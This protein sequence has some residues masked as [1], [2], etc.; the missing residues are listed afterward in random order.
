MKRI[1]ALILTVPLL[2]AGC[3]DATT[4]ADSPPSDASTE[5]TPESTTA[6]AEPAVAEIGDPIP[7]TCFWEDCLGEVTFTNI[8]IDEECRYGLANYGESSNASTEDKELVQL[9]GEFSLTKG[10]G[11]QNGEEN[12]TSLQ[13]P[14]SVIDADGFIQT[15][16]AYQ[17]ED[18]TDG[19]EDW[20]KIIDASQK[21]RIY[22]NFLVPAGATALIVE[23]YTITLPGREI[24][25]NALMELPSREELESA[26]NSGSPVEDLELIEDMGTT[27]GIYYDAKNSDYRFCDSSGIN[28]LD[29]LGPDGCSEG[30][31]YE[32]LQVA[33]ADS[34][35]RSF[36]TETP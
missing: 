12:S 2:L 4:T 31:S 18:A 6:T 17:C 20:G 11:G 19:Y 21:V 35:A 27:L 25:E 14:T 32:E 9:W 29:I 8:V 10:P 22:G 30:M 24:S 26:A 7:V 16:V 23:D 5:V 15:P 28:P 3:S 13:D 34:F 33:F 36:E 1:A